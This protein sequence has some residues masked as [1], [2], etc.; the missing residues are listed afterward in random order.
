MSVGESGVAR[1]LRKYLRAFSPSEWGSYVHS[2]QILRFKVRGLVDADLSDF[3]ISTD[4]T[5][6]L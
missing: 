4:E 3:S 5:T 6:K 2:E 1:L